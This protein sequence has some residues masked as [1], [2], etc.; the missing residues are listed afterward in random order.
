MNH[1]TLQPGH[2][3]G[4]TSIGSQVT[5]PSADGVLVDPHIKG[6]REKERATK[7]L[8]DKRDFWEKGLAAETLLLKVQATSPSIKSEFI[9]RYVAIYQRSEGSCMHACHICG[10]IQPSLKA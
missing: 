4:V 2:R 5:L 6:K 9:H 10:K 1:T 8:E 3:R 7:E